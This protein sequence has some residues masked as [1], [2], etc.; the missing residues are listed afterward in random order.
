VK[1]QKKKPNAMVSMEILEII[2]LVESYNKC[3][4]CEDI[5]YG[6]DDFQMTY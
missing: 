4:L 1:K 3:L 6:F 2:D 5:F